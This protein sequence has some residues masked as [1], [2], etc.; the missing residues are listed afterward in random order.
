MRWC[1]A[2]F[3]LDESK[4]TLTR[5]GREVSIQPKAFALLV[6]LLRNREHVVSQREVLEA[7]WPEATVGEAALLSAIRKVRHAVGD[8]GRAQKMIRTVP[9]R[10]F[11]WASPVR[12][13]DAAADESTDSPA[14]PAQPERPGLGRRGPAL[15]VLPFRCVDGGGPFLSDG[16]SQELRLAL[17]WFDGLRVVGAETSQH[18]DEDPAGG[19]ARRTGARF[20]LSGTVGTTATELRV[21][22]Q[23]SELDTEELLWAERFSD[24]LHGSNPFSAQIRISRIVAARI[25]DHHGVVVRRLYEEINRHQVRHYSTVEAVMRFHYNQLSHAPGSHEEARKALVAASEEEP[26]YAPVL[27]MLSELEADEVGVRGGDGRET[28]VEARRLAERAIALD[29]TCQQAHWSLAWV[30]FL[31]RNREAF[32]AAAERALAHNPNNAYL[33]A[34][35][36]WCRALMGDWTEGLGLLE[37]GMTLNPIGPGWFHLAH[38]LDR[39]RVGDYDGALVAAERVGLP[40]LVLEWTIRISALHRLGRDEEARAAGLR[41]LE[42]APDAEVAVEAHLAALVHDEELVRRVSEDVRAALAETRL[43]RTAVQQRA[44]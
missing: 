7:V 11:R 34:L 40:H 19:L 4:G 41:L 39:Y 10:G 36:G 22:A 44:G 23:L 8:D 31:S 9:R 25:A 29:P 13:L 43:A 16:F 28:L 12:L 33:T 14:A 35:V 3:E 1:F 26:D 37:S 32:V 18:I 20:V 2:E 30:E 15:V 17:S 21:S 42:V 5:H 38:F 6:F 24:P 27:A